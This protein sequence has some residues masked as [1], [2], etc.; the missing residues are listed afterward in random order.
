MRSLWGMMLLSALQAAQPSSAQSQRSAE[1]A[2]RTGGGQPRVTLHVR[3]ILQANVGSS[4][5]FDIEPVDRPPLSANDSL[6]V[7]VEPISGS[8]IEWHRAIELSKSSPYYLRLTF[9]KIGL[10]RLQMVPQ[11]SALAP[12]PRWRATFVVGVGV[13]TPASDLQ[14]KINSARSQMVSGRGTRN[15]AKGLTH[16]PDIM[17]SL[18]EQWEELSAAL[19]EKKTPAQL[20]QQAQRIADHTLHVPGHVPTRLARN[21][22]EFERYA[23]QL[24]Q[25]TLVLVKLMND[26]GQALAQMKKVE[27][28]TCS[29]CHAHFRFNVPEETNEVNEPNKNR[30]EVLAVKVGDDAHGA[31]LFSAFCLSCHAPEKRSENE[32]PPPAR[33]PSPRNLADPNYLFRRTDDD[34]MT[35]LTLGGRAV[36]SHALMP[37][38]GGPAGVLD[39]W[40]L[41]SYL[42]KDQPSLSALF[43]S[44]ADWTTKEYVLEGDFLAR[45][46][47]LTGPISEPERNVTVGEAFGPQRQK[48]GYFSFQTMFLPGIA[49][50]VNVGLAVD[51]SGTIRKLVAYGSDGQ[52][53]ERAAPL[54][55]PFEGEKAEKLASP[56]TLGKNA[57]RVTRPLNRFYVR[58]REA[59]RTAGVLRLK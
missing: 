22:Q 34:L 12:V 14:E 48:L 16:L 45:L 42:R 53:Q 31:R 18:G 36:K 59:L 23:V 10:Y 37:S 27:N 43:P 4:L 8:S 29:Q 2:Y 5:L 9:P 21:V 19:G 30:P 57:D 56:L 7:G 39:A 41:V 38:F 6:L 25:E 28:Q 40:D 1:S 44:L 51:A 52:I 33:R 50:S 20:T 13:P 54:L 17:Q 24:R 15:S 3:S 58:I 49:R 32:T 26:P 55:V 11:S 46:T 47:E 35:V